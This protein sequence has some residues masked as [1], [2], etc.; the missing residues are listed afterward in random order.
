M[1]INDQILG[2]A[3]NKL[4]NPSQSSRDS[5]SLQLS[6]FYSMYNILRVKNCASS[7]LPSWCTCQLKP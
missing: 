7:L 4:S 5:A 6:M 3:V 2:G 1:Q